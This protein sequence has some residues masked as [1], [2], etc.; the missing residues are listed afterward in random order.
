MTTK[1]LIKLFKFICKLN[2]IK[3]SGFYFGRWSVFAYPIWSNAERGQVAFKVY[4]YLGV[5]ST[6]VRYAKMACA[7]AVT[8]LTAGVAS[9]ATGL[10]SVGAG[11]GDIS[12]K[13]GGLSEA[14][15]VDIGAVQLSH[16]LKHHKRPEQ[17]G[18]AIINSGK[19]LHRAIIRV[20]AKSFGWQVYYR[21]ATD[22]WVSDFYT[23]NASKMDDSGISIDRRYAVFPGG[24]VISNR[25]QG[26]NYINR[27]VHS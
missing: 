1:Q 17:V 4:A 13:Y 12:G 2:G 10:G 5:D 18:A 3:S 25:G 20:D 6:K 22:A 24:N 7:H 8:C 16:V 11:L 9:G 23:Q 14:F 27:T 26:G 15:N 21:N 19:M